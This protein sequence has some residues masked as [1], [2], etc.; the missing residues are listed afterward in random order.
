MIRKKYFK[1]NYMFD[2]DLHWGRK[3]VPRTDINHTT[4]TP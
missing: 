2:D 4:K 3:K 1:E